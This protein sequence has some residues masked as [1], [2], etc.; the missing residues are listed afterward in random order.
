MTGKLAIPEE[1][2][3]LVTG[4][5]GPTLVCTRFGKVG[6]TIE[7]GVLSGPLVAAFKHSKRLGYRS[8]SRSVVR[9]IGLDLTRIEQTKGFAFQ[10]TG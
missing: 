9:R 7:L 10:M 6:I 3:G 8:K 2:A 4:Q 1:N 5:R